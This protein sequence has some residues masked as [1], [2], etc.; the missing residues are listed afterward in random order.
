MLYKRNWHNTVT[1]LYFNNNS[2]KKPLGFLKLV[3]SFLKLYQGSLGSQLLTGFKN[4]CPKRQALHKPLHP[5]IKILFT[6]NVS[7]LWRAWNFQSWVPHL[8]QSQRRPKPALHETCWSLFWASWAP[9]PGGEMISIHISAMKE[10]APDL[11]VGVA[12]LGEEKKEPGGTLLLSQVKEAS[13]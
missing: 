9:E 12:W 13:A 11:C 8:H 2:N 7:P 3:G 4:L 1:Q 5:Q 6:L 10:E